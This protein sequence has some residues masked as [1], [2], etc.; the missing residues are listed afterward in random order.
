MYNR[1]ESNRSKILDF[2][3]LGATFTVDWLERSVYYVQT[4]ENLPNSA[5]YK[6]DLNRYEK[7]IVKSKQIVKALGVV[8]DIEVSPYSR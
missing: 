1:Q 7:G 6:M 5:V 2:N 8:A 4:K 3:G